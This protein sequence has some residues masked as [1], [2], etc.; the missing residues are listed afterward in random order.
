[1]FMPEV[2]T[3][4]LPQATCAMADLLRVLSDNSI[5]WIISEHVRV[6]S[7]AELE[8]VAFLSFHSAVNSQPL[9]PR[10]AW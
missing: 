2:P 7:C 4:G 3:A 8:R 9:R 6:S 10:G 5:V 1:M